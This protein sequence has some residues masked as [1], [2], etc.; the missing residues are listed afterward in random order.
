MSFPAS[1]RAAVAPGRAAT[2]LGLRVFLRGWLEDLGTDLAR[3]AIHLTFLAHQAWDMLDAVG[4]TLARLITGQG[5]FLQWET[6]AA[7]AQRARRL[8]CARILRRDARE[9]DHRRRRACSPSLI[10][11]PH[12]LAGGAADPA[13]V[14]RRAAD[15]VPPQQARAVVAAGDHRRRPRV[16]EDGGARPRGST[17]RR[18]SPRT[19]AGCRRTTCSS[20]RNRASR[21]APRRPTSR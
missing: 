5:R 13:A 12:G 1:R 3:V 7:V 21:I 6:A 9:P 20:I 18:S 17:S 14:D 10:A 4:V 19:I 2:G 11:R 8:G 15:R 16:P